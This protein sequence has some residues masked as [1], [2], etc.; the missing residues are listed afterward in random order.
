M[1]VH[2]AQAVTILAVRVG[3]EGAN[4]VEDAREERVAAKAEARAARGA[5]REIE[6]SHGNEIDQARC[7]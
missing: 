3:A 5:L 1:P 4:L 7:A 2:P 6:S